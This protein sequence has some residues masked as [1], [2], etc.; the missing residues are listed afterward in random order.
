MSFDL[1]KAVRDYKENGFVSGIPALSE[2]TVQK[3]RA[4][5]EDLEAKHAE[6]ANGHTLNQFFRVNGHVVIPEFAEAA[7]TPHILDIVE[8]LLGPDLLAWSVELFI[9]EPGTTK[10]VSWH[11]DITYWGMGETDDEVAE[12]MDHL[13][14]AD[15]DF[16]TIGQYLQPTPKH[17]P[18]DRFWTPEEFDSL[19]NL[20]EAKGFLMISAT[21]LTRSSYH[22]DDDFAALKAARQGATS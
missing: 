4:Y 18:L 21:P 15:V 10:T 8:E 22:A 13:R 9:K 2:S 11:Q 12:M 19:K 5:I 3:M 7:R 1:A 16:M 20:G 17:H 6:G 14:A